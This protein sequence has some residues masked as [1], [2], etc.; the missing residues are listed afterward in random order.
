LFVLVNPFTECFENIKDASLFIKLGQMLAIAFIT[1]CSI[2]NFLL[3]WQQG[4]AEN[5]ALILS[6]SAATSQW[7]EKSQRIFSVG[8]MLP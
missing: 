2:L 3:P 6:I 1:T 8:Y 5:F 4:T 7:I